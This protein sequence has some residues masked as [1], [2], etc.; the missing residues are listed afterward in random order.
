VFLTG[1]LILE[2]RKRELKQRKTG[3]FQKENRENRVISKSERKYK[4]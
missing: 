4:G 1:L 2:D 3:W